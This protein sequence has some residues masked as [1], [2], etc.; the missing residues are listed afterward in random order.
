MAKTKIL[1]KIKLDEFINKIH[2]WEVRPPDR[3]HITT[4]TSE[5]LS[6]ENTYILIYKELTDNLF[7]Y[8]YS[9]LVIFFGWLN[10]ENRTFR[11]VCDI[12]TYTSQKC[13]AE[14]K[15]RIM[16]IEFKIKLSNKLPLKKEKKSETQIYVYNQI[17]VEINSFTSW[18]CQVR[19][20]QQ[21]QDQLTF[22]EQLDI[23]S[24]S[25]HHPSLKFRL[26]PIY[27]YISFI[28]YYYQ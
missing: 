5:T 18:I 17:K 23:S 8:T 16:Q 19:D 1:I 20:F 7:H 9:D 6:L 24:P 21:Q 3:K 2:T 28:M 13:S 27:V 14:Y 25:A 15:K 4:A 11:M 12:V 22:V 26:W 10:N